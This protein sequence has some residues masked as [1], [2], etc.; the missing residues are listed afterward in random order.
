M[1]PVN[2]ESLTHRNHQNV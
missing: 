2:H 1:L